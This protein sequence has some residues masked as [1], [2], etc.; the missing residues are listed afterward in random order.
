MDSLVT[1]ARECRMT[2]SRYELPVISGAR[3]SSAIADPAAPHPPHRYP[4]GA[5]WIYGL[6]LGDDFAK[7]ARIN[8][9]SYLSS[10]TRR[11]I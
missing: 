2:A 10:F 11:A 4:V 3:L 6:G 1:F 5:L 9:V 8:R 7:L